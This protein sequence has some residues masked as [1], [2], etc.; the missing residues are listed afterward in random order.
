MSEEPEC[1]LATCCWPPHVGDFSVTSHPLPTLTL[2]HGSHRRQNGLWEDLSDPAQLCYSPPPCGQHPRLPPPPHTHQENAPS[3]EAGLS[4]PRPPRCCP[5]TCTA[6][7]IRNRAGKRWPVSS[8]RAGVHSGRC[9]DRR[10]SNK[11]FKVLC[12]EVPPHRQGRE[13]RQAAHEI[14]STG[15]VSRGGTGQVGARAAHCGMPLTAELGLGPR[16]SV[17]LCFRAGNDTPW[18]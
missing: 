13:G 1:N 17:G 10:C 2:S 9:G 16:Q 14:V 8:G 11:R 7:D 15:G 3:N 6:P 5:N 4:T 12:D 18:P